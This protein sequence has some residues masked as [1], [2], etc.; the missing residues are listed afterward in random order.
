MA[1][2][3]RTMRAYRPSLSA[4]APQEDG[5]EARRQK[6]NNLHRYAERAL[7]GLPL[8]GDNPREP[9]ELAQS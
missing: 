4:A 8:F 2:R 5:E 7:R 1:E 9:G 3:I 6:E